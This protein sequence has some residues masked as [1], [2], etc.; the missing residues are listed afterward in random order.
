MVLLLLLF[1]LVLLQEQLADTTTYV[2][3]WR[4][5]IDYVGED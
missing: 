2:Q 3:A 5:A 4:L 1:Q